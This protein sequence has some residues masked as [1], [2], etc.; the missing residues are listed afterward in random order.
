M[1]SQALD[2]LVEGGA[3]K[4]AVLAQKHGGQEKAVLDTVGGLQDWTSGDTV[5]LGR[6]IPYRTLSDL[7]A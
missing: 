5:A 4:G 3:A 7:V 2:G 6:T 1:D